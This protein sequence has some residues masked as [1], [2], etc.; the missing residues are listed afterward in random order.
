MKKKWTQ[1]GGAMAAIGLFSAS[2]AVAADG[3]RKAT[4]DH[5]NI[6]FILADDLGYGDL[7]FYGS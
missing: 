1:I 3:Q 6:I 7:S 5:P 4:P 2:E